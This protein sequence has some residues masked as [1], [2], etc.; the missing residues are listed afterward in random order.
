MMSAVVES[1]DFRLETK[2]QMS[3]S[4]RPTKELK[5]YGILVLG[6]THCTIALRRPL[7]NFWRGEMAG[8]KK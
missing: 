3:S 2:I 8:E 7:S 6:E 4:V 1:S 5:L